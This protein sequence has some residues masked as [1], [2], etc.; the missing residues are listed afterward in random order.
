[1]RDDLNGFTEVVSSSLSISEIRLRIWI[2]AHLPL[3]NVLIDLSG[4]HVVVFAQTD[5]EVALV[6]A[7]I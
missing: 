6:I 2:L 4:G 7:E 1:M 3:D 5:I